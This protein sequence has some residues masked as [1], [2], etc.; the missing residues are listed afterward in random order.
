MA[1]GADE[2]EDDGEEAEAVKGAE[3]ADAEELKGVRGEKR[4]G[5]EVRGRMKESR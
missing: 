2:G 1:F 5:A 4:G 3:E